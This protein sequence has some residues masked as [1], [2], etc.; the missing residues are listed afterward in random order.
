MAV[1]FAGKNIIHPGA[2][3][4]VDSGALGVLGA[5]ASRKIV[6]VGSSEGGKP[7][8]IHWFS[9]PSDAKK[10]LRGGDLY[11]AGELAWTPSGD[12]VGAGTIGFLRVDSAKQSQLVKGNMIL[13]SKD[14]GAHTNQIQAKL[15]DGSIPNSKKLT[16]YFWPDDVTEVYDNLGPIFNI[17]HTGTEAVAELT[18]TKDANG[19]ANKLEIKVGETAA[20]TVLVSVPLGEKSPYRDTATLVNHL[21]SYPDIEA[22]LKSVGNKNIPTELLDA[23]S[24]Q[25]IKSEYDVLAL[26][27]EIK[28][29]LNLSQLV[30]VEFGQG[31]FPDNFPFEY[32]TG[33]D[34][35]TV[36]VSWANEF[37]KVFGTGAYFLVPLT[38]D[39]AIH[40]EALQYV[41]S[42]S[43][44]EQNYMMTILG[45]NLN[46]TV[47]QVISRAVYLNSKRAVLCYPG[48]VRNIAGGTETLPPYFLA[49]MVAGRLSGKDTGDPV[50]MDYLNLISLEKILSKAEI[51]RLISNGVTVVEYVNNYNRQGYR[52]VQG[53]TTYQKDSN[54]SYREIGMAMIVDE[55]NAELIDLLESKYVGTKGTISA[56]SLMKNDVQ[57][58]LDRKVREEVINEYDPNSVTVRLSGDVVYVHYS[59]IPVGAI[60]YVLITAEL[61]QRPVEA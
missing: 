50:T 58:F 42:Q 26:E 8:V 1:N 27:G 39:E 12:G 54:P 10:V 57:S 53:V 15:E 17:K 45:G 23:V 30:D 31:T 9:N 51:E 13:K 49:A 21:N 3:A 16:I 18:I 33:G 29:R 41:E 19:K 61:Y 38:G 56:I 44:N 34:N 20:D 60:N 36:P 24:A 59:A 40:A 55:L 47:D 6:F 48:I 4:K 43:Q 32:F 5:A 35:G 11:K 28:N 7:G 37:A 22:S 25:D 52:I 46:E 14:Y 2:Y